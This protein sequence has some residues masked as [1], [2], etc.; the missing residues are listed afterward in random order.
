MSMGTPHWMAAGLALR[1]QA[2]G[3]GDVL[4]RHPG[5]LRDPVQRILGRPGRAAPRSRYTT[6]PRTLV[7]EAFGDDDVQHAQGEGGVGAGP[8]LQELLRP[9]A[10]QV[11]RGSMTM[12]LEP[13]FMQ[14]SDPVAVE[15][16]LAAGGRVLR[17][18]HDHLRQPVLRIGH[19]VGEE[20]A[21]IQDGVV[22]VGEHHGGQTGR[23]A[24]VTGQPQ[25]YPVGT[26]EGVA[27]EGDGSAHIP[28]GPLGE[29]HGF[30]PVGLLDLVETLLRP[31]PG[32]RP[33]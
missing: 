3:G 26:A 10:N 27:E 18:D 30:R 2:G 32:L 14:S 23:V 8:Q 24:G 15:A 5:D 1:V 17:P 4:G 16:V 11:Q 20:L 21:G 31:C 29:D 6:S 28:P 25:L 12:S 22:A 9:G 33:R 13:R 7:V 19:A